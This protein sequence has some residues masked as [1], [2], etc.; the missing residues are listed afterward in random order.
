MDLRAITPEPSAAASERT[1]PRSPMH[2]RAIT[3][4][5]SAVSEYTYTD[6]LPACSTRYLLP[7]LVD[8]VKG[9]PKGSVVVD[10]GSGNGSLLANLPLD[11]MELNGLEISESGVAEARKS[12][13]GI[14]FSQADLTADLSSHALAGRCDLAISTEVIEH[15]FL[16]RAFVRNCHRLLKPGGLLV[17]ST[18]YH[19]YLKNL[20]LA[21]S[22]KLDSHFTALWDYGHIKFWSKKTLTYLLE[23]AGFAIREFRGAG[24]VPF[25]WK[26]MIVVAVK[27]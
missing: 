21:A 8:I 17:I 15:V 24:R 20:A 26:S 14:H 1:R 5:P 11:S 27:A 13:P 7:A 16:P 4:E 18:P 25:L 22:G 9:L 2:L 10:L 3:P 12:Y 19:G 23:E 6:S